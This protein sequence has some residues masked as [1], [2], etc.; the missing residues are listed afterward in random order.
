MTKWI[1]IRPIVVVVCIILY[2]CVVNTI[3]ICI[4]LICLVWWDIVADIIV[5]YW[6]FIA[7][8]RR[9]LTPVAIEYI[10]KESGNWLYILKWIVLSI[11]RARLVGSSVVLRKN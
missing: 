4:V 2:E 5:S 3:V 7:A 11:N 8:L 1:V 10:C 9:N 6:G